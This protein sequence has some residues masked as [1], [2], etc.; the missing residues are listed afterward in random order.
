MRKCYG[1]FKIKTIACLDLLKDNQ[2]REK[3]KKEKN[4]T[5]DVSK[6]LDLTDRFCSPSTKGP[7]LGSECEIQTLTIVPL[8]FEIMVIKRG[9]WI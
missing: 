3:K 7:K 5:E 9:L 1:I 6:I 2:S 4:R 8:A